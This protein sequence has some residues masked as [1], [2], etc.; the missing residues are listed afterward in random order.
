MSPAVLPNI[1]GTNLRAVR[2]SLEQYE[3]QLHARPGQKGLTPDQTEEL[4]G[5]FEFV[6]QTIEWSWDRLQA[7][8][9]EGTEGRKMARTLRAIHEQIKEVL[10]AYAKFQEINTAFPPDY[11][12]FPA[13][14]TNVTEA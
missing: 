7:E 10:M 13:S 12:G 11:P 5:W 1:L 8:I 14:A 6:A 2:H 4:I 3:Q 9:R